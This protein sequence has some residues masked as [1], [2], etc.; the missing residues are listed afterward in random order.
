[1]IHSNR[2]SL[3]GKTVTLNSKAKDIIQG[4]VVPGAK[5]VV[6]DY[7]DRIG[8]K[9]VWLTTG[10]FAAMNYALRNQTA[11]LPMDEEVVYGKI[12]G[13]GHIVHVSEIDETSVA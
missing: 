12:N 7:W 11:G 3:A 5:F 9:S 10:N 4:Q 2:H 8:G 6:E 13:L 1:M